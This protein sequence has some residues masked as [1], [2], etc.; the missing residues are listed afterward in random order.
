[1]Y[2][3][4][5][6]TVPGKIESTAGR[7]RPGIASSSAATRGRIMM[8]PAGVVDLIEHLCLFVRSGH[9]SGVGGVVILAVGRFLKVA[10]LVSKR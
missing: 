7:D 2:A 1:M 6:S 3:H 4:R 10:A 5:Q 8:L 9:C